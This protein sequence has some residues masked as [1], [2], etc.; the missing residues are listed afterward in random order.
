MPGIP[1]FIVR[2]TQGIVCIVG[3]QSK[4]SGVQETTRRLS[5]VISGAF[6]AEARTL[7]LFQRKQL[8]SL[9]VIQNL[10]GAPCFQGLARICRLDRQTDF[11]DACAILAVGEKE[12]RDVR[13]LCFR[14]HKSLLEQVVIHQPPV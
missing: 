10:A 8:S 5:G 6:V 2:R 13:I 9:P 1:A 4:D 7:L 3:A 12:N 14:P 11:N